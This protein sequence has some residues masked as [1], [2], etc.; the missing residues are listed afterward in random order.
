MLQL[1]I[2]KCVKN[3]MMVTVMLQYFPDDALC[4]TVSDQAHQFITAVF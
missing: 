2:N 3:L 4:D 1:L